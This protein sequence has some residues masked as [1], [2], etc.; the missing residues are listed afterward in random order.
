[1]SSIY[2]NLPNYPK[3]GYWNIVANYYGSQKRTYFKVE[4][5]YLAL[6]EVVVSMPEIVTLNTFPLEAM[7]DGA[8]V[9][10]RLAQGN[11]TAHWYFQSDIVSM[12]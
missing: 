1:M 9:T 8:F 3:I 7:I 11:I 10:E 4:K 5:H 2:Y 12:H 6:F